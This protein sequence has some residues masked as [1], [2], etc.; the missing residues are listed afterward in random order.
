M[1]LVHSDRTWPVTPTHDLLRFVEAAH[2]E[3]QSALLDQAARGIDALQ[4]ALGEA[5]DRGREA[6]ERGD[7]GDFQATLRMIEMQA[8]LVGRMVARLAARARPS[9]PERRLVDLNALV[10]DTL[11]FLTPRTDAVVRLASRLAAELPRVLGCP[12]QLRHAVTNLIV[13]AARRMTGA[14]QGGTITIVT[15]RAAAVLHGEGLVRVEVLDEGP[16][17][18]GSTL[19][20]LFE[21]RSAQDA[22]GGGRGLSL[23]HAGRIVGEHGGVLS[24]RNRAEGGACFTVELPAL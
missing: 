1:R 22:A 8:D 15:S 4:S 23:Y 9:G 3:T 5:L 24:V 2:R 11:R 18:P 12:R 19:S 20:R 7:L 14:G 10:A 6:V 17:I 21:R 13:Y 16:A